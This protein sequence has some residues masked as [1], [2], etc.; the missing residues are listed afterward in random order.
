MSAPLDVRTDLSARDDLAVTMV[1]APTRRRRGLTPD[2]A[3][4]YWLDA[5][6]PSI[7]ALP[8]LSVYTQHHLEHEH[9]DLGPGL[10][11]S[12][13]V[14]KVRGRARATHVLVFRGERTLAGELGA[15]RA[16][17]VAETGSLHLW[18]GAAV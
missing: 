8:G 1:L 14:Q 2:T 12:P 18:S 5:H 16:R 4:A 15:H 6:G 3:A 9:G 13:L 10:A 11:R 17:L 7:A